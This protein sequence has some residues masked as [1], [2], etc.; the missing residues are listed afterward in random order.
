MV[1]ATLCLVGVRRVGV[2]GVGALG[3][4]GCEP[5]E[6][7]APSLCRPCSGKLSLRQTRRVRWTVECTS[8]MRKRAWA[9][10]SSLIVS[11]S[12]RLWRDV[13]CGMK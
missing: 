3:V 6:A 11:D 9:H 4:A 2:L 5:W 12:T 7:W 8:D 10:S 1:A 13:A